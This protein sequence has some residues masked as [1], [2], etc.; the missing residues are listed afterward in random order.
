MCAP[1][2][3]AQGTAPLSLATARNAAHRVHPEITA[4]REAVMAAQAGE[5]QASAYPNPTFAYRREQTAGDGQSNA[6]NVSSIDQPI[7]LGLRGSR[8]DVARARREAAEARLA[9]TRLELDHDVTVAYARAVAADR[10]ARVAEQAGAAFTEALRVSEQRLA[11]G[12]V[13]GY[14]HRRLRLEAARAATAR[15]EAVLE[16]R[17]ARVV[18]ASLISAADA[19][20]APSS[21]ILSDTLVGVLT[22]PAADSL[23]AMAQQIRADFRALQLDAE[24]SA[25]EARLAARARLPVPVLSAGFKNER[26]G[27]PGAGTYSLDGF[28]AGISLSLPIFDRR[29]G[30][31]DAAEAETRRQLALVESRRRRIAREVLEAHDAYR[32]AQ[33]QVALLEPVVGPDARAALAAADVAYAEGE[34]MLVE[35]LD[36]M[37]SYREAEASFASLQA[38]V[39]IR[40]AALE[41]AVG[42][43]FTQVR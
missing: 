10:R 6:Q 32:V 28:V 23:V 9:F 1:S 12:D 33:E 21:M 37:R 35:W 4:A 7:E 15:V 16:A 31:V 8:R 22:T 36:V 41:R 27:Q 14:S 11:A 24:G 3:H 39:L 25:A 5:R 19:S 34:I 13:A 38:E 26:L 29:R 18:L 17:T 43:P 40:R 20:L 2:L 42:S 30:A